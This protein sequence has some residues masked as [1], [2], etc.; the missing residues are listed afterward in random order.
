MLKSSIIGAM[1]V[2]LGM[3]AAD[4]ETGV[5]RAKA[6]S[7]GLKGELAGLAKSF[8]PLASAAGAGAAAVAAVSFGF[9]KAAEAARFAD[10]L[11]AAADRIGV[12]A[13]ALQELRHA[14]EATD[15]PVEALEAGLEKLNATLGALQSGIGAGKIKAAFATLGIPPET[16]R[17]LNTAEELLPLI[18][19]RIWQVGSHAE[20]VQIARK[21]GVED[22]LPLLRRGKDGLAE[23]RDE[24]RDLGLVMGEEVAVNLADM[25]EKMRV[26]DA[27]A[28]AAGRNL[29]A[30]LTPA[31]VKVKN[32]IA[33]ATNAL[34]RWIAKVRESNFAGGPGP[35]RAMA[36]LLG[37]GQSQLTSES[38]AAGLE[39]RTSPPDE[40]PRA[41]G[42]GSSKRRSNLPPTQ[43]VEVRSADLS[44]YVDISK[45]T[46]D[47]LIEPFREASSLGTLQGALDGLQRSREDVRESYRWAIARGLEAAVY[48][49]GKG[50]MHYLADQFRLRLID[51]LADGLSRA[52]EE[53][54][55]GGGGKGGWLP[56]GMMSV[57]KAL[58]FSTGGSFRVGGTGGPDSQLVPLRL[59]PG[60]VVDVRRPG[61][62]VG[63][64][65]EIVIRV[66]KSPLFE[67]EVQKIAGPIAA[68]AGVQAAQA[69]AAMAERNFV[70]RGRQRLG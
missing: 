17:S 61:D 15:V 25:N 48:G 43:E 40:A 23:L 30:V 53:I 33:E 63:F 26:A 60:E 4:F 44:T 66:E 34:A 8:G 50:L 18:A 67:V 10:D 28:Q 21:L 9:Q 54:A 3:D 37:R 64:G 59:T 55:F 41:P 62:G 27:R 5:A 19:E 56:A 31:L 1:R 38:I 45:V 36:W 46:K 29:G 22:L 6:Q 32:G 20:Q 35:L 16:I 11:V 13:E 65:G 2:K 49:G 69:G 39:P 51:R 70:R 7:S 24:A 68:R 42:G 12:S 58:G 14:A 57:T 47:D 52:L